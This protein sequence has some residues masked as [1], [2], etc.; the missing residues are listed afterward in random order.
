MFRFLCSKKFGKIEN[1]SFIGY[2]YPPPPIF[3]YNNNITSSSYE[4]ENHFIAPPPPHYEEKP[5]IELPYTPLPSSSPSTAASTK[6][7]SDDEKTVKDPSNE[8]DQMKIKVVEK[9]GGKLLEVTGTKVDA[10]GEASPSG[11][12]IKLKLTKLEVEY[13]MKEKQQLQEIDLL[14][15]KLEETERAMANIIA[16]MDS[17]PGQKKVRCNFNFD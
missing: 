11:T 7:Q 12:P 9:L 14:R 6:N 13:S 10:K 15:K 3:H 16:R 4:S 1:S 2:I 5:A 17:I 8:Y